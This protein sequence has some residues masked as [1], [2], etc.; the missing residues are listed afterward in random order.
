[1]TSQARGGDR[2]VYAQRTR[3]I[4][5]RILSSFETVVWPP[6]E[7]AETAA[8]RPRASVDVGARMRSMW[9]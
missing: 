7:A 1:V 9:R 4:P 5:E 2:H 8:P 3:F 6:A